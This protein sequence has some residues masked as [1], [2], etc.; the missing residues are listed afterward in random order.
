MRPGDFTAA[1]LA[2][3]TALPS[4]RTVLVT[5]VGSARFYL[6]VSKTL[7]AVYFLI[8]RHYGYENLTWKRAKSK[9]FHNKKI[10]TQSVLLLSFTQHHQ[11][12]PG[13]CF[14]WKSLRE[15]FGNQLAEIEL[16]QK[17]LMQQVIR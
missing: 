10:A 13:R 5:R 15:I 8:H 16:F 6:P 12:Q 4:L 9:S 2:S 3:K 11:R 7:E 17:S 1:Q 14:P